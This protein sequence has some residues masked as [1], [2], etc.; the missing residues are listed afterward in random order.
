M[1]SYLVDIVIGS[2]TD[3]PVLESSGM[4][5]VLER[6]GVSYE[7]SVISA[8]RNP[9]VLTAHCDEAR[10]KGVKIF[11]AGAGMAARLPGTIAAHTRY[12][13]VVIGVPLPSE[14]FPNALDAL[15]SIGRA[16]AGCPV[17]FTG[18]GQAGFRNAALHAVQILANGDD[19]IGRRIKD[20]LI[21]YYSNTRKDPEIGF[22]KSQRKKNLCFLG[23]EKGWTYRGKVRDTYDLGDGL[24]LIVATDRISAFDVVIPNGVPSKGFVLNNLSAFWFELTKHIIPNH[25][26]RVV[27]DVTTLP[28][29]FPHVFNGRSMVV[30]K[31]ERIDVEC[32]ARGYLSGSAWAEYKQYGTVAGLSMPKGL[33]ESDKLPQVLFTPTTKAEK[34]HDEPITIKQMEDMFG[35][36]LTEEIVAKTLE[37]YNVADTYARNRG[38]I[39]ADTK[40]EFGMINDKLSLID[41]LLT[42]DSSRFWDAEDYEPGRVQKSFDKQPVRDCLVASGWNKEPPAPELPE[43]VILAT[44]QRY[45]EV[46][47]RLTGRPLD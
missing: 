38:I 25:L 28:G 42:P 4:F 16:P 15:L 31:A 27:D 12:I 29:H 36:E 41:E 30:R 37:V 45:R 32:I 10:Q 24:L 6:C 44:T 18:V 23:L 7:A 11:I 17:A 40:M 46:Y 8:D 34:D 43:E 2:K 22:R 20:K 35:K 3:R 47:E 13:P 33:K 26:V 14:D 21:T 9:G 19:E 5:E 39:I 1:E